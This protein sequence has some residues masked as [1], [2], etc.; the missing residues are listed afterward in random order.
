VENKIKYLKILQDS[1]EKGKI[2]KKKY[3]KELE[4]VRSIC[5]KNP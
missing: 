1:F 4:F 2:S 5:V 3:K